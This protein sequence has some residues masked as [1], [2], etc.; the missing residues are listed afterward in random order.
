MEAGGLRRD[1]SSGSATRECRLALDSLD[2][3]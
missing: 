2:L 3:T 1:I